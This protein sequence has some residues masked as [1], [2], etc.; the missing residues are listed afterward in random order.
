[1]EYLSRVMDYAVNT[2]PFRFHLLCKNLKLN[3]LLFANDLLMFC[4]GDVNSI[5]LV[6]RVLSTFSATS[7]L[8]INA[9]K[10]EVVFNGVAGWL[11]QDIVQVSGFSEGKLPFKYLGVPIQ[12]G[13]LSR[14][15]CNI[16]IERIF[17]RIRGIGAKKLSYAG[18]VILINA[19]LNT[20]HNYWASIFLIPKGV[21]KRIEAICRNFLWS[22]SSE[23]SRSPLVA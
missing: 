8:R 7:R 21:I 16:L 5:M 12:P 14:L 15:D 23:Y 18:R 22:G 3:H 1:M 4:K 11:K 13:R 10:S 6:L 2:W 17:S 20:L 19:V 9:F